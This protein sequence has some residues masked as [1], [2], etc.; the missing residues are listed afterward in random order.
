[1][2]RIQ[3]TKNDWVFDDKTQNIIWCLTSE[4]PTVQ[5]RNLWGRPGS[6]VEFRTRPGVETYQ[7]QLCQELGRLAELAPDWLL[8][9]MQPIRAQFAC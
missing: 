8:T 5:G 2:T 3:D 7:L 6:A 9:L 4:A 1:M